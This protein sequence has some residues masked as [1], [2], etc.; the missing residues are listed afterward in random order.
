MAA[1]PSPL[2]D[3]L[4][5]ELLVAVL[6]HLGAQDLRRVALVH[7]RL[8]LLACTAIAPPAPRTAGRASVLEQQLEMPPPP[9]GC[10]CATP[11]H[12]RWTL[13]QAAAWLQLQL[14]YCEV[15]RGWV[16]RMPL[17]G[18]Q[19]GRQSSQPARCWLWAL[20]EVEALKQPFRFTRCHDLIELSDEAAVA[21]NSMS[22]AAGDTEAVA[23]ATALGGA[24]MR[25][26]QHYCEFTWLAGSLSMV[27]VVTDSSAANERVA[28]A[29]DVGELW[30]T[31]SAYFYS[32]EDGHRV[33]WG[34]EFS[35]SV[36]TARHANA[37]HVAPI[38]HLFPLGTGVAAKQGSSPRVDS[39][40]RRLLVV[41]GTG[42]AAAARNWETGSG[43]RWTVTEARSLSTSTASGSE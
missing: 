5:E 3:T 32:T 9:A 22:L 28:R 1:P 33:H 12:L 2:F 8:G 39:L 20:A 36:T 34:D 30:L 16:P 11:N 4:T 38:S 15:E 14:H 6:T 43:W 23:W 10:K 18:T 17:P 29:L 24:V 13:V 7:P 31:P 41:H 19:R 40:L 42:T 26:G 27:G 25:A 21:T 37:Q 35:W